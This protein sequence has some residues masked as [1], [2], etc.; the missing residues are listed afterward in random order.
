MI[1]VQ[2][3][4]SL[5]CGY[6]KNIQISNDEALLIF[7]SIQYGFRSIQLSLYFNDDGF[8]TNRLLWLIHHACANLH[9]KQLTRTLQAL[10]A[11]RFVIHCDAVQFTIQYVRVFINITFSKWFPIKIK[12]SNEWFNTIFRFRM[13]NKNES[14]YLNLAWCY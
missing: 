10:H 14:L 11:S 9:T 8:I 6:S 3:C 2:Y 5:L 1:H 7:R 4:V 12:Y 13:F